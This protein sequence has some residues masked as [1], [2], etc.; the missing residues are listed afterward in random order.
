[1]QRTVYSA[2]AECIHAPVGPCSASV[3]VPPCHPD[4]PKTVKRFT[5]AN[6]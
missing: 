4:P 5:H 2:L 1:M 6:R 3:N